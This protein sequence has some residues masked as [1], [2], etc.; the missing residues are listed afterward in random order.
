MRALEDSYNYLTK[1]KTD[2]FTACQIPLQVFYNLDVRISLRE[3]Q[4][5]LGD[6]SHR[7]LAGV[8]IDLYKLAPKELINLGGFEP[9]QLRREQTLKS[10]ALTT[11]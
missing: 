1:V 10:H 8:P 4:F 3:T 7:L 11:G 5:I 6:Q 2:Y 9:E